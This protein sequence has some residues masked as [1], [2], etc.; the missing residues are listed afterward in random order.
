MKKEG[1]EESGQ[2]TESLEPAMVTT[3][4]LVPDNPERV[5]MMT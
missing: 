3:S 4:Q 5:I 1:I 2:Y